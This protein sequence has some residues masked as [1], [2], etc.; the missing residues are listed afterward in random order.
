MIT[1]Y[2]ATI[3]VDLKLSP[4]SD[5]QTAR[6]HV[7]LLTVRPSWLLLYEWLESPL[8]IQMRLNPQG[9]LL[10]TLSLP[11]LLTKVLV[12]LKSGLDSPNMKWTSVTS[13]N[14]RQFVLLTRRSF[15]LSRH[16]LSE[17]QLPITFLR[18][19]TLGK[20]PDTFINPHFYT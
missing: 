10:V 8:I 16:N 19:P 9:K 14:F 4:P 7:S 18:P 20:F 6:L 11:F 12:S 5:L 1:I 15:H 17:S 3:L 13:N 2:P